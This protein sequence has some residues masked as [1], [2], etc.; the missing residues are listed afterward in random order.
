MGFFDAVNHAMATIATGG[1]STKNESVGAFDSLYIE[2]VIIFFM[3]ISGMSFS[4]QFRAISTG[5]LGKISESPEVRVYFWITVTAIALVTAN[6][7]GSGAYHS[8]GEALR[9]S[10]FEVV[11]IITTTGFGINPEADFDMWPDFSR[12]V[13]VCIM[14]IGACAGSTAGGIK[15][16]RIYVV[17]KHA[18]VELRRL[19]R[20]RLVQTIQIGDREVPQ[21]TTDAI[22]G[23]FL[24]YFTI[25][26]VMGLAMTALGLDIISGTTAAVS[27]MNSIGPGLGTVGGSESFS[28]VPDSGLYLLSGGMLMGRL[29]IYPFLVIFS[30]HFW[31]RG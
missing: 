28:H 14:L 25:I 15:S 3:F 12:I 27:A 24:L 7:F 29:E 1:F 5:K 21:E 20:P 19:V 9:Y 22:L 10:S 8:I 16:V 4:L 18:M 6:T 13:M 23:F 11:S 26:L 17:A 30:S 31:R 2:L